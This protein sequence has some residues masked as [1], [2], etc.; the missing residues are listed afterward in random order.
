MY[1]RQWDKC[2]SMEYE[3][4]SINYH[5]VI[6]KMKVKWNI[7]NN[8][9]LLHC[10]KFTFYEDS[11]VLINLNISNAHKQTTFNFY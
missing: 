4:I 11:Y 8:K 3:H 7:I 6:G 2:V 5:L 1:Q 10:L 9:H